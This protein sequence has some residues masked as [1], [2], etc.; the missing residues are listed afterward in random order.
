MQLV[1]IKRIY[2]T[3]WDE[4]KVNSNLNL[5]IICP[6]PPLNIFSI[7][8]NYIYIYKGKKQ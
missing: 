5:K 7:I 4:L 1:V 2:E 8:M 3:I 6:P